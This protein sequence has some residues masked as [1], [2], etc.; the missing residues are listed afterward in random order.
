MNTLKSK[1]L[2]TSVL[3][4]IISMILISMVSMFTFISTN[5]EILKF[6]ETDMIQEKQQLIKNQI[7][8][9]KNVVDS[10]LSK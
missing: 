3:P 1:L 4:L 10:V 8:T 6:Y 9:A 7:S 5:E 2:A